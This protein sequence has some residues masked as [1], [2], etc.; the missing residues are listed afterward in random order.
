MKISFARGRTCR[1][2]NTLFINVVDVAVSARQPPV[3]LT[4]SSSSSVP[5]PVDARARSPQILCL[6]S[7]PLLP[8][9]SFRLSLSSAR[10]VPWITPHSLGIYSRPFES[11][12]RPREREI[13]RR[14][15][16]AS[17]DVP[18]LPPTSPPSPMTS[19]G[20][21]LRKGDRDLAGSR[22]SGLCH[23]FETGTSRFLVNF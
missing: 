20:R 3:Y 9:L 19:L 23:L 15:L 17:F 10:C 14:R 22:A 4:L 6:S 5:F 13:A 18:S 8:P 1:E 16:A 12:M 7:P 11:L 21:A 2:I